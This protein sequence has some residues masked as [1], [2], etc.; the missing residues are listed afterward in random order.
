VNQEFYES[1]LLDANRLFNGWKNPAK[2]GTLYD[3]YAVSSR[4]R[5]FGNLLYPNSSDDQLGTIESRPIPITK[6]QLIVPRLQTQLFYATGRIQ[7][8]YMA[9]T[10]T[11]HPVHQLAGPTGL[12]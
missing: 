9:T 1:N 2:A 12:P 4:T 3:R 11:V 8:A 6:A 7:T 5:N 10:V